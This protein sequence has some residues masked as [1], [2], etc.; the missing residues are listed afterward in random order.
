MILGRSDAVADFDPNAFDV[1]IS[2]CGCGA[3][4]DPDDKKPWKERPVFQDW[5]LDD[6]PV[7]TVSFEKRE[8]CC[9]DNFLSA[10]DMLTSK[11]QAID[12]GDLSAYRR[13]RDE[14]KAKC[15]ELLN[16]L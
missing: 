8:V 15:E 7:R 9:G 11:L 16:S 4:L 1:V 12:P 2:C 3:K 5:N 14:C 10:S 13:V 6:P